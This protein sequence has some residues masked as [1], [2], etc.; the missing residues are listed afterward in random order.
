MVSFKEFLMALKEIYYYWIRLILFWVKLDY[1]INT[2]CGLFLWFY[3]G[4]NQSDK[5]L[6]LCLC[7][8][9][10]WK[11]IMILH[12]SLPTYRGSTLYPKSTQISC[13]LCFIYSSYWILSILQLLVLFKST[14][15]NLSYCQSILINNRLF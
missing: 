9:I 13:L 6:F 11:Y 2:F 15:Q 7:W 4:C 1:I 10:D 12:F 8:D 5:L 3:L 14:Y